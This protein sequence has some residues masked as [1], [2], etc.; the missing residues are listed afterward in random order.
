VAWGLQFPDA[1]VRIYEVLVLSGPILV[2]VVVGAHVLYALFYGFTYRMPPLLACAAIILA[3]NRPY[4]RW[5]LELR[6]LR[7]RRKL[8]VIRGDR[9]GG[10]YYPN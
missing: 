10:P 2:V 4:D 7:A 1:R 6:R 3:I 8:G 9:H 5:L